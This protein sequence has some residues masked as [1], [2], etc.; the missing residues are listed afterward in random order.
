[1]DIIVSTRNENKFNEISKILS[2]AKINAISLEKFPRAPK[3]IKE[4]G[5]TFADNACIKALKIAGSTKRLTVADDSGLEVYALNNAPGVYSARFSGKGATYETN[6][7]KLLELLN[8]VPKTKRKAR[9]V[10]CVAVADKEG[11]IGV[12]KGICQ[13]TIAFSE[14]GKKGFGYDPLFICNEYNKTFAQLSPVIKN[15][16]SHRAKAFAKAKKIILRYID[17]KDKI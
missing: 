10:C 13:G 5:D 3:K 16:I 1:M 8:G 15:Q 6:N 14:K 12:V 11:I 4:D 2:D 17:K 9:F 7:K